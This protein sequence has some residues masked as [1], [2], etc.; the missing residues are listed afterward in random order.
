MDESV[1]GSTISVIS[2]GAVLNRTRVFGSNF[3]LYPGVDYSLN[4]NI[5]SLLLSFWQTQQESQWSVLR[6]H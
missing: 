2:G 1:W 3:Q 5:L 4:V 6:R